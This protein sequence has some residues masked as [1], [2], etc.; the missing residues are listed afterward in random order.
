LAL[1]PPDFFVDWAYKVDHWCK[2]PVYGSALRNAVDPETG[3]LSAKSIEQVHNSL[4]RLRSLLTNQT[5]ETIDAFIAENEGIA[6]HAKL[7]IAS[8]LL[9]RTYHL[10]DG[11][12]RIGHL[13]SRY[14]P[15]SKP[16]SPPDRNWI[17]LLINIVRHG[18]DNHT[19]SP[20]NKVQI[21]TFNY[22]SILEHVLERQ[23]K[24]RERPLN[25]YTQY[26]EIEHVHGKFPD[27]QDQCDDPGKIAA[28]WANEIFVVNE[29]N[30]PDGIRLARERA[31]Y[32]ISH[33]D[34]LYAVG[35][36]FAGPNCR[37]I[38]LNSLA[39]PGATLTYCNYDGDRGVK[40]A[41][42]RHA[43]PFT[44]LEF[45]GDWSRQLGVSAFI[46]GGHLG[47]PPG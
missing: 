33:A 35:F 1:K 16:D 13:G 15:V 5:A 10:S 8:L 47:E 23:F 25:D 39:R 20:A 3:K 6:P 9:Q 27:I 12:L 45:T 19:V 44:L 24:N 46:R 26:F 18:I 34:K 14:L 43:S 32:M 42:S 28:S 36:S 38:G 4:Q 31:K 37:L 21:V 30:P 40:E 29:S 11:R 7:A 41:A 17:H 2:N 22:D